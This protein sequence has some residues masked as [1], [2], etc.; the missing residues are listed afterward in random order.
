M[1]LLAVGTSHH[2]APLEIRERVAFARDEQAEMIREIHAL[3]T[4][5]E[6]VLVSTC[7]R[8]EIYSVVSVENSL[9]IHDW[10]CSRAQLD[11]EQAKSCLYSRHNYQAVEHLF[12]VASGL[13]SL[14]LGEPQILGQLKEAWQFSHDNQA[15]GKVTDRLFQHAF[16]TGKSVRTTTGISSHP[17]SVAYIA[18][19]LARQI[20]GDLS[21]KQVVLI[22]AGEM[23][24]LCARH[25]LQQG[26]TRLVI[27]NRS[28]EKARTLAQEFNA[29]A[30]GLDNL[31]KVLPQADILVTST[32]SRT[33]ILT[34][35]LV[36]SAI[37]ARKHQPMFL[38]D[39]AVPRDI[40]ASVAGLDDAYL[41][42][43]DDL[44]Q[45]ADENHSERSRAAEAAEDAVQSA[46]LEFMRWLHGA[47]AADSLQRLRAHA[48]RSGEELALRAIRQIQA[49]KDPHQVVQQMASTLTHRILHLPSKRLRQA[50]EEQDY[51]TLKAADRLFE[52]GPE[53]EDSTE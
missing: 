6:A 25:F 30:V 45:V 31:A 11:A 24:E 33:P 26:V 22:G 15:M 2:T 27:V 17:V 39:I 5:E 16:A 43:I 3:P 14:V 49:G 18:M 38:V 41:Y 52:A 20:F 13:D 23:I 35:A 36:K 40:E 10:F 12:R 32:G 37:K 8:T 34:K 50:A 29:E 53:S 4:V 47:R 19:I 48:E 28:I 42:T 51:E 44:Q 46:A 9:C 7:N 21:T 1:P